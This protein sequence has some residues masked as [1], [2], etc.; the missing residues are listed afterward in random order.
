MMMVPMPKASTDEPPSP[1]MGWG[2]MGLSDWKSE[3]NGEMW[4]EAPE[5]MMKGRW[6]EERGTC[7]EETRADSGEGTA[8]AGEKGTKGRSKEEGGRGSAEKAKLT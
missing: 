8:D 1:L 4:Q 2:V 3:R 5:S 7:G 6:E